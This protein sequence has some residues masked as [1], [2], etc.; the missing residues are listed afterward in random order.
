MSTIVDFLVKIPEIVLYGCAILVA[1]TFAM[2]VWLFWKGRQLEAQVDALTN[3]LKKFATG[4]FSGRSIGVSL[5]TVENIR[6]VCETLPD[7]PR[8]WWKV[9]DS[10]IEQYTSPEEVEGWFLTERPRDVLPYE[11]VIGK[12]FNAAIFSA[13]PGLLTGAG[14]TLT[15]I[16]ILLALYGVHYERRIQSIRSAV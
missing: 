10:H 15:F 6:S 9:I 5:E 2:F 7:K 4:D 14:L 16:A 3:T 1:V 12:N 11:V 8:E 13:F